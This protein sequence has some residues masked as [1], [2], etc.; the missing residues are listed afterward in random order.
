VRRTRREATTCQRDESTNAPGSD[1][2]AGRAPR[3]AERATPRRTP[4]DPRV[5][6]ER[7]STQA[8]RRGS[9]KAT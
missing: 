6:S 7:S 4:T 9:V 8:F 2:G 5:R 3:C 1:I